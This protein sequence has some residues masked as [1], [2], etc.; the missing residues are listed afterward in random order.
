MALRPRRTC[1]LPASLA[2]LDRSPFDVC[3]LNRSWR[4]PVATVSGSRC[5]PE[6]FEVQTLITIESVRLESGLNLPAS[7]CH[8]EHAARREIFFVDVIRR[9]EPDDARR[10][11]TSRS[12]VA[13]RT[14]R[15]GADVAHCAR[16]T[17]RGPAIDRPADFL[18]GRGGGFPPDPATAFSRS[19]ACGHSRS[20]RPIRRASLVPRRQPTPGRNPTKI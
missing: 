9:V 13:A 8:P 2:P 18:V 20:I 12:P 4:S 10:S 15:S 6:R 5:L 14:I 7:A 17:R 3:A 19:H 16:R 1:P 11:D